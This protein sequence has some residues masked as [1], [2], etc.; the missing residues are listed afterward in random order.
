ML[1]FMQ[2]RG[3]IAI[4]GREGNDRIWDLAHRVMPAGQPEITAEDVERIRSE[5]R[6]RSL[7]IARP[8]VV[9]GIG[10][11]VE[12]EGVEGT[13]V[14][15]PKWLRRPF[16]GRTATLSPFDRLIHE[17]RRLLDLFGFDY[18]LEIYVPPA[19]RRWGYY[20]LPVLHGTRFIGRFDAKAD[21]EAS[22]LRVPAIHMEPGTNQKDVA[23]VNGELQELAD[24][25]GLDRVA[26]GNVIREPR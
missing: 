4:S 18:K 11:P 19:M 14:A 23:T 10:V 15:D 5:R 12:V 22:V 7:G 20:V 26:V 17:R 25:L 24:W 6:L 1:E 8:K 2:A 21:R 16:K 9:G 13:W 3:E